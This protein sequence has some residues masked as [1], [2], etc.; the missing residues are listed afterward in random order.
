MIVFNKAFIL[1]VMVV[2]VCAIVD[3][4]IDMFGSGGNITKE[5]CQKICKQMIEGNKQC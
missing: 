2:L 5:E 4:L 3:L 1:I